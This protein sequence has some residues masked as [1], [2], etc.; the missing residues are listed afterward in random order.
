MKRGLF[1]ITVMLMALVANAQMP[2]FH[3]DFEDGSTIPNDVNLV[4]GAVYQDVNGGDSITLNTEA[5]TVDMKNGNQSL[6]MANSGHISFLSDDFLTDHEVYT[7][8]FWMK[9]D[10]LISGVETVQSTGGSPDLINVT[11]F[12]EGTKNVLTVSRVC[13]LSKYRKTLVYTNGTGQLA[14]IGLF[15]YDESGVETTAGP[16]WVYVTFAQ[17][18]SEY[19]AGR[20]QV[21]YNG[22]FSHD[23]PIAG[24][25]LEMVSNEDADIKFHIGTRMALE[26]DTFVPRVAS[27]VYNTGISGYLDDVKLYGEELSPAQITALYGGGASVQLSIANNIVNPIL[28]ADGVVMSK[29]DTILSAGLHTFTISA[30]GY[31]DSTISITIAGVDTILPEINL[32]EDVVTSIQE[33]SAQAFYPNP[34]SS[35]LTF[36]VVELRHIY[37]LSGQKVMSSSDRIIDISSLDEGLYIIKSQRYSEK[38]IK[39]N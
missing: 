3:L 15:G 33:V 6:Q 20:A 19:E 17:G 23:R 9:W 10:N 31:I 21:Y 26:G 8:S 7:I 36:D 37:N 16:E 32:N 30:D 14:P 24:S 28:K 4:D 29:M 18:Y 27:Q 38:F 39:I 2:I 22:V 13:N 1:T 25:I 11:G 5:T 12:R 34:T 35:T